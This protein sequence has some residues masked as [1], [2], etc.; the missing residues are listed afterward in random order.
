MDMP[1]SR[2]GTHLAARDR[3]LALGGGCWVALAARWAEAVVARIDAGLAT[4]SLDATLPDGRRVRLGGRAPGPAAAIVLA[5]WMPVV[6]LM[7][8]GIGGVRARAFRRRLDLA[9]PGSDLRAVRR[10][11]D[12]ARQRGAGARACRGSLNRLVRA[13]EER[14]RP[15]R[16]IEFHYD[17][18]NDFYA[19]WLDP[20]MTYSSA[21]FDADRRPRS[22]ADA[23]DPRAARRGRGPARRPACS[24]SAAAGAASPRSRRATMA[25]TSTAS[26]CRPSSSPTPA[27]GVPGRPSA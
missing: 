9:R 1:T 2:R 4:G 7:L 12:D 25:R 27:R 8:V 23:Q 21:L 24:R 13:V 14:L 18:G 22:R 10:Q 26:R 20:G 6:R 3:R 19:A 5:N 11:P 16:N 15:R 17:L